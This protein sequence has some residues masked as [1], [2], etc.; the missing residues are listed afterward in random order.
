MFYELDSSLDQAGKEG[1][2]EILS[3]SQ[4]LLFFLLWKMIKPVRLITKGSK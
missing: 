1:D 2:R 3:N 4:L